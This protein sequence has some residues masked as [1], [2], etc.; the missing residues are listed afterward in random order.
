MRRKE[1]G[2]DQY[3]QYLR[4]GSAFSSQVNR[5]MR[6]RPL[7]ADRDA[8][9]GFFT[10][11][12]ETLEVLKERQVLTIVDQADAG[13]THYD[14][15]VREA[16][17]WPGWQE[18]PPEA[19]EDYYARLSK[20]WELASMVL[21]NSRWSKSALIEQGVPSEKI[22]VVPCAY[23]A[24]P[25]RTRAKREKS[26]TLSVLWAGNVVL[27]KGI[28]YLIEAAKLLSNEDVRFV[29][30]GAIGISDAAIAL[31]PDNVTFLGRVTR[32]RMDEIYREADIFI[33]PTLSDGFGMTQ[34]E[35]M[36]HG[37]PVIATPN[38]GDVVSDGLDGFIVP[39]GDARA[40]AEAVNR[41]AS[42]KD[43]VE[44]MSARALE[45]SRQFT[46]AGYT[47]RLTEAVDQ[48]RGDYEQS[49]PAQHPTQGR[50]APKA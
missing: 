19:P 36:G 37:L 27:A 14:V 44:E 41:F 38:C 49:A 33:F 42:Q 10:G 34:V 2:P 3:L 35:A 4:E 5:H 40:L 32:D 7:E 26:R 29:V 23:E 24:S 28:A 8:F 22:V 1:S 39:A 11:C 47:S 12:L 9:F 31:A 18:V 17:K 15:A 16:M 50:L 13:R 46:L 48:Y 30:A 25:V 6:R 43:L 45:K 21:V 20:E